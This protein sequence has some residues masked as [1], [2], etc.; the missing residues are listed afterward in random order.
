MK[1]FSAAAL[2]VF[3]IFFSAAPETQAQVRL[4]SVGYF[5]GDDSCGFER[6][7]E[8]VAESYLIKRQRDGSFALARS[9]GGQALV[10]NLTKKGFSAA[11]KGQRG[12]EFFREKVKVKLKGRRGEAVWTIRVITGGQ[13]CIM[14]YYGDVLRVE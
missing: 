3:G 4:Y 6:V 10:N 9:T 13:A 1:F 2:I 14:K 8:E 5:L 11:F 12:A 7:K